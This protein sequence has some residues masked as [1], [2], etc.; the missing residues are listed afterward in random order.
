MTQEE[1]GMVRAFI[2]ERVKPRDFNLKEIE[3][4]L[5]FY[6]SPEGEQ[7]KDHLV[8]KPWLALNVEYLEWYASVFYCYDLA[9]EELLPKKMVPLSSRRKVKENLFFCLGLLFKVYDLL[10]MSHA[11]LFGGAPTRLVPHGCSVLKEWLS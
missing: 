11:P 9:L 3:W 5:S 6:P 4:L 7:I 1:F 8:I 2:L 10:R